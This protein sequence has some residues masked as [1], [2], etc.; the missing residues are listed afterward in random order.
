VEG[1]ASARGE[2]QRALVEIAVP[3]ERHARTPVVGDFVIVPLG[4]QRDLGIELAQVRIE[5][6]VFVIAAEVRQRLRHPGLLFGDEVAPDFAVRQLQPRRDRAIGIDVVAGMDEEIGAASRHRRVAAHAAA[7]LVD[8]PT[9][10]GGVARPHERDRAPFARRGAK[11][12]DL[13]LAENRR[14]GVVLETDAVEDVLPGRQAF[15]ERL[16]GEV[17]FRQRVDMDRAA[18]GLEAV[19]GGDLDQHA[20]GPVGARP[21]HAGIDRDVARLDA[22][23][24]D[25]PI[26]RAA[27]RGFGDALQQAHRRGRAGSREEGATRQRRAP[28]H[29]DGHWASAV[30]SRR[31]MRASSDNDPTV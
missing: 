8:A 18:D 15:E 10:A 25:R 6:V 7:R 13:R 16:G 22:V 17:G 2:L 26:G 5:Q 27:E 28:A 3:C 29:G 20:R 14:R 11:A 12:S 1:P 21:D 9:A 23:G 19:G 24:D 31:T 30:E 4:E